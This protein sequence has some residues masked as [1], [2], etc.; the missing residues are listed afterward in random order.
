M[1]I[2]KR[3]TESQFSDSEATNWRELNEGFWR[4]E[5]GKPRVEW[6]KKG[7]LKVILPLT[8]TPSEQ[9]RQLE[10]M[11]ELPPDTQQSARTWY[12]VNPK[13]G[14][15]PKAGG[16]FNPSYLTDFMCAALGTE[17]GKKFRKW[18]EKG[19]G[20]P[21]PAD[22]DDDKAEIELLTN[23]LGWFEGLEVYGTITHGQGDGGKIWANFAGPMPV[24][25]LP[26][27]PEHEYQ[28]LCRGKARALVHEGGP[29]EGEP[30]VKPE[31]VAAAKKRT[32]EETFPEDKDD[33]PF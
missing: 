14:F 29:V 10:M 15:F 19:G 1:P 9:T 5:I 31:P 28:A 2:V 22:K 16:P 8:L 3:V 12:R 11:D 18:I 32:Y 24:G 20:P 13:L 30:P 21:R 26:G 17:N 25:S 33:A 4:F 23:W 27:Q 7:D 6:N